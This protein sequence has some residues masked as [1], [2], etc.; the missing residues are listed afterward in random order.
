M[1]ELVDK[2]KDMNFLLAFILVGT[3]VALL[4]RDVLE[5]LQIP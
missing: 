5:R 2:M 3:L 1:N 4:I